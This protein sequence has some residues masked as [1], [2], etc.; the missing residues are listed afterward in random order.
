MAK[1][2]DQY[3]SGVD[4]LAIKDA[5]RVSAIVDQGHAV[6][7]PTSWPEDDLLAQR[8]CAV[9]VVTLSFGRIAGTLRVAGRRDQNVNDSGDRRW[10]GHIRSFPQLLSRL[11]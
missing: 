10:R 3:M 4:E 1:Y 8:S 5:L 11:T 6:E 2:Y 7:L 9:P